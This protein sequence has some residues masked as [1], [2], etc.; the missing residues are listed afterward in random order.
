MKQKS[1]KKICIVV[2]CLSKGGAEKIAGVLSEI[3]F[4]KG[5]YDITIISLRDDISYPYSGT[6]INLGVNVSNFKIVKQVQKF[7]RLKK[8]IKQL[9]SDYVIDF[10]TRSR[11]I[12]EGLLHLFVWESKKMIFTVH[13]YHIDWHLPKGRFFVEYY[14][15]GKVVAVSK[16]IKKLLEDSYGFNNVTFIPNVVNEAHI[17][18]LA[19]RKEINNN[20]IIAIARLLNDVKQLD[21]LI[22]T[23]SKTSLAKQGVKLYILG[24]GPDKENLN[25]LINKLQLKEHVKLLGFVENP[26]PYIKQAMFK[27][28]CSKVEGLPMVILE[29]LTL[30]TPVISFNCNSGPSEMIDHNVNGILVQDQDFDK[31]K[32]AIEYLANNEVV[33]N[34][35]KQNTSAN[36]EF[37]SE[38]NHYKK[39][40]TL[41]T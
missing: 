34:S 24:D 16:S 41:L 18:S 21:K 38:E 32:K 30:N 4:N 27:V 36:L 25:S 11:I 7:F 26:Y 14:K 28:L 19:I 2:D 9:N 15:K 13:N 1:S 22:L 20:Y 31:L 23:Y 37:Y 5:G 6:L 3:L 29:A 33:L 10:R 8:H 40:K 17:K 12:M 39:W 35:F